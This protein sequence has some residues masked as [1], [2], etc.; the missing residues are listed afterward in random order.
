MFMKLTSHLCSPSDVRSEDVVPWPFAC[1]EQEDAVRTHSQLQWLAHEVDTPASKQQHAH[2]HARTQ[3]L[4]PCEDPG[5]SSSISRKIRGSP[6][7]ALRSRLP[8]PPP[9][10]RGSNRGSPTT[11]AKCREEGEGERR[12]EK[13]GGGGGGEEG[14]RRRDK[15]GGREREGQRE[16]GE[17]RVG[18]NNAKNA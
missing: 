5:G 7:S 14:E 13:G 17:G 15:G 6:P 9:L 11:E 4:P 8:S 10:K 12:R 18:R 2:T 1:M 3:C 16:K